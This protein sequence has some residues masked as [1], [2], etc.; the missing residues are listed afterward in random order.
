MPKWVKTSAAGKIAVARRLVEAFLVEGPRQ[1][2]AVAR[3]IAT[4][5]SAAG[6]AAAH[7][8]KGTLQTFHDTDSA[9]IASRIESH[10]RRGD[11]GAAGHDVPA[12]RREVERLRASLSEWSS[13]TAP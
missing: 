2:D 4:G 9:S 7:R 11:L 5:D 6:A 8:L 10:A 3:A 13:M 1:V 12:L